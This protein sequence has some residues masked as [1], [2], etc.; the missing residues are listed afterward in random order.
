MNSLSTHGNRRHRSAF[1]LVELLAALLILTVAV[2]VTGLIIRETRMTAARLSEA[3]EA[4]RE[5][6][7]IMELIK[8]DVERAI[9]YTSIPAFAI[10]E[11][12][13]HVATLE[14][15]GVVVGPGTNSP[16]VPAG[17]SNAARLFLL[18]LDEKPRTGPTDRAITEVSYWLASGTSDAFPTLVRGERP[19]T[20]DHMS[21]FGNASWHLSTNGLTVETVARFVTDFSVRGTTPDWQVVTSP[22]SLPVCV[23]VH[24]EYLPESAARRLQASG[25][26]TNLVEIER[27]VNKTS[28]RVFPPNRRGYLDGR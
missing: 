27:C 24:I 19:I 11:G 17:A 10:I 6:F 16:V 14:D 13:I 26:L 9:A 22:G 20:T 12:G 1:T 25:S 15:S 7:R 4:S 28:I 18:T 8:R 21:S 3:G 23:D 2:T 5:T